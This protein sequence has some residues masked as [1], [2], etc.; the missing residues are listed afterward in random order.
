M[1]GLGPGGIE[2]IESRLGTKKNQGGF[3]VGKRKGGMA[4]QGVDWWSKRREGY[5]FPWEGGI[6]LGEEW[7]K[8]RRSH[9]EK[10]AEVRQE[11]G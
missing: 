8:S 10:T 6:S 11:G 4:R 1:E 9:F 7:G 5:C 3:L 2:H